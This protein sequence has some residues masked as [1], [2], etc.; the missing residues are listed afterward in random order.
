MNDKFLSL[1]GLAR[2]SG[3]VSLGHDAVINSIV[4]S[5]AKLCVMSKDASERLQKEIKHACTYENKN[6]P[7]IV[8][9]YDLTELSSAVG[10]K[11]AVISVDDEGFAKALTD[12]YNK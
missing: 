12:K 8:T 2:R 7:V 6:I 3:R 1:L 10:S 5:K 9:H 4:R 11:A